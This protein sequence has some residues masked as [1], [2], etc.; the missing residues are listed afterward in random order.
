MNSYNQRSFSGTA[1]DTTLVS[2]MDDVTLTVTCADLTGWPDGS[3]G[4]FEVTFEPGKAAEEKCWASARSGNTLTLLA[5]GMEGGAA[6]HAGTTTT[7]RHG[8]SA[9]D[10]S[11]AN[12]AVAQTVGQVA[13][14]GDLLVGSAANTLT[15]VPVGSTG[16][17]L[18]VAAGTWAPGDIANPTGTSGSVVLSTD[19]AYQGLNIGTAGAT[20][21]TTPT[22][23]AGTYLFLSTLRAEAVS[24]EDQITVNVVPG[25]ATATISGAA[26]TAYVP[27]ITSGFGAVNATAAQLVTVTAAGTMA[28]TASAFTGVT[29]FGSS[30]CVYVRLA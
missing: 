19:P 5:R 25:T 21:V 7:V 3:G 4:P 30:G 16:Q 13:A 20:I 23:V 10:M 2:S 15:A 28:V 8:L 22:L 26:A 12:Y 24:G 17:A 29:A 27:S 11:E 1:P 9:L 6:A 14:K 18:I